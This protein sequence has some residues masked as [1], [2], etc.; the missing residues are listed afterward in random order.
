MYKRQE[1]TGDP[2]G[3]LREPGF[4][5]L[6]SRAG[7]VTTGVPSDTATCPDCLAELFD[8]ADRRWRHAF[9]N[10][11]QCGPRYTLTRALPYDRTQTSMAAFTQCPA[12]LREYTDPAHRRFHAEPNACPD[13]GPR[14]H[15]L[16]ADAQ[17]LPGDAVAAALALLRDGG[18]VAIKGLGGFHLACNALDAAAV[19]RLRERKQREEKPF[20]VMVA[21]LPSAARWVQA[22][23]SEQALLA[24]PERPIV[25]L[26]Q[27]DGQPAPAGIAPGLS[28]PVSYTH[29]TLPTSDLV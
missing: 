18:I 5:I 27:R 13:C 9:I 12:C 20:A 19:A 15:L 29:L 7:R 22:D 21:N 28:A 6:A 11:T 8:P 4:H 25:L 10:C 14:L 3:A 16:G 2:Q 26:P 17:P 1:V 24:A 23:A